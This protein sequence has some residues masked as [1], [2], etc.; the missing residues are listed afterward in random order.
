LN[1]I[2]Q[3]IEDFKFFEKEFSLTTSKKEHGEN[4][5]TNMLNEL[6]RYT[7]AGMKYQP[8]CSTSTYDIWTLREGT[9]PTIQS[10]DG[11]IISYFDIISTP[12]TTYSSR[13][14]GACALEKNP[15]CATA[16]DGATKYITSLKD[17]YDKNLVLLGK[18]ISETSQIRLNDMKTDFEKMRSEEFYDFTSEECLASYFRAKH[19][20]A[21]LQTMTVE[22]DDYR[23]TIEDLIPGIPESSTVA[24]PF[25][26]DHGHGIKLGENVFI[27][28]NGT[29][30]DGGIITIGSNTQIGP[31]CQFLT[32]NHP[33]DYVERRKPIERC[34]PI[35]IGEDCWLGGGVTV[36][37]GVTIGDRCIIGAG[38]VVVKDIPSDSIAVG[39]P[40]RVIRK[41]NQNR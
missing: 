3:V 39:N 21:K 11:K 6:N 34:S 35:T 15:P 5:I 28:Y 36:C 17:Y 23:K 1:S 32:P 29:M 38:S 27:N 24:P 26:C 16:Q 31:N 14:S 10:V 37:P 18:M 7:F 2:D 40:C 19:L 9:S 12:S 33:I 13:Y 41:T 30:L 8:I 25:H 22:D 4:D 20:C